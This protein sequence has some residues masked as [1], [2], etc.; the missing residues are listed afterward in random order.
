MHVLSRMNRFIITMAGCLFFSLSVAQSDQQYFTGDNTDETGFDKILKSARR[1]TRDLENLPPSFSIKQYAPAPG[2]Q[3]TQGTC[4]AWSTAYAART[5]SY[6][7]Q[8]QV[9][10][11]SQ[12]N[13]AAFSPN[14]L[15]Y[16]IKTDGD[17]DCTKGAKIEP[18]L[19]VLADRGNLLLNENLPDCT[20]SI[21]NTADKK[22]KDYIIKAYTSLTNTFGR[23]SKNE[24]LAI[25]KSIAEKK[26]VI[27]SLKCYKSF[28]TTGK[29]GVWNMPAGDSLIGNHAICIVGYDDNKAGGAFEIINSWGSTWGNDGFGWISYD[30]MIRFGSYALELMDREVYEPAVRRSLSPPEIKGNISFVLT[31]DFGNDIGEMPVL[32]APVVANGVD[33][34]DAA[35][36]AYHLVQQYA[37]GQRF[38]IKFTTNAPAFVYIFSIDDRQTVSSMFPYAANVSPA[39]NSTDATVYLPSE[40]KN[41]KLNADA[42][43]EKICVLYSKSAIDFENLKNKIASVTAGDLSKTIASVYRQ[44]LIAANKINFEKGQISFSS[45]A[46]ESELICFF[47]DLKRQ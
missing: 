15:Y 24:V 10:D 6:C 27:F 7:I 13:A 29:D 3:G 35:L 37:A 20:G 22:A 42:D 40:T 36:A 41:Y 14:Y 1:A 19:K 16:Y 9:T 43:R 45:P 31:N 39:I 25:K 47:I 5:I 12:I 4:V 17:N 34:N 38:K 33:K 28:T 23:V 11:K 18:A 26:P 30:Q 2:T 21:D 32:L 44:Q 8:H 46:A